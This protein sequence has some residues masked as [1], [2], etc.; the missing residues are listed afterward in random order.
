ML[1]LGA[2]TDCADPAGGTAMAG[3]AGTANTGGSAAGAAH[4]AAEVVELDDWHRRV[5]GGGSASSSSVS[6][7]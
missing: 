2:A 3:A 1:F 5:R 7:R 4:A 6:N